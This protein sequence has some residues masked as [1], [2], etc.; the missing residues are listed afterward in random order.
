MGLKALLSPNYKSLKATKSLFRSRDI[1]HSHSLVESQALI[2]PF[3][4]LFIITIEKLLWR[5]QDR[6]T[7]ASSKETL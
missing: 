5:L 3:E 6:G 2:G 4:L 7:R 1:T